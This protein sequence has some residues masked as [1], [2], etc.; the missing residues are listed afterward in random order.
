MFVLDGSA[1]VRQ[2]NMATKVV[3]TLAGGGGPPG[4]ATT[5]TVLDG[6]GTA[7]IF[8]QPASLAADNDNVWVA[9]FNSWRI[10]K[11]VIA[12]GVTTSFAGGNNPG[13][14]VRHGVQ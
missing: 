6:L 12:T 9:D 14:A 2:V 1:S 3:T 13:W 11:V 5:N 4:C 8:N 7:A 10:R